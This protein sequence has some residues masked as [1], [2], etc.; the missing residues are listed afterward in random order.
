ILI[1]L[2]IL[3][4]SFSAAGQDFLSF[5]WDSL[6]LEAGFLA[7][8]LGRTRII[9]WMFRWL[10]FRLMFLSGAV[11]LISQDKTWRNLSALSFHYHTQPLPTVLAWYADKLPPWFQHASTAMALVTELAIPFLIF[12][13]RRIR[14]FGAWSLIALQVLIFLTGNYTFFN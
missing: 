4:L 2:F 12:M 7:I 6:L 9:P 14:M 11:K 10:A 3:Y 1:L 5:Q 13:P 8:F